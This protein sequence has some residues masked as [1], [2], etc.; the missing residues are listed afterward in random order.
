MLCLVGVEFF[1]I[2]DSLS[3]ALPNNPCYHNLEEDSFYKHYE[4]RRKC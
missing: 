1:S 3:E 2:K 4:N